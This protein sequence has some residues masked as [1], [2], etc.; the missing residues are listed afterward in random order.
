MKLQQADYERLIARL[1]NTGS[2]AGSSAEEIADIRQ[3]AARCLK[4]ALQ[5]IAD[6]EREVADMRRALE[7]AAIETNV[8]R[9]A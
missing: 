8:A 9:D 6:L 2:P 1:E 4:D 3:E 7:R 5:R